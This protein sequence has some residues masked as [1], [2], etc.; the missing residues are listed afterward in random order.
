MKVTKFKLAR[1]F[2]GY[3]QSELAKM[4]GVTPG[5]V[6]QWEQGK[7]APNIKL[8]KPLAGLLGMSVEELLNDLEEVG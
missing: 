7:T 3:T 1:M 8:L 4:L 5:A 6:S 2:S